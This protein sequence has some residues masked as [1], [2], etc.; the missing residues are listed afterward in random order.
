MI[1]PNIDSI[2][3]RIITI[4][5]V[6]CLVTLSAGFII[7]TVMDIKRIKSNLAD[8]ASIAAKLVGASC[9]SALTFDYPKTA[10]KNLKTLK[11]FPG[12]LNA[13][14]LDSKGAVFA[15]YDPS[16]KLPEKFSNTDKRFFSY[17]DNFLYV[18]EPVV[19]QGKTYGSILLQISPEIKKEIQ[20]RVLIASILVLCLVFI[21]FLLA[22]FA[23]KVISAPILTLAEIS[24]EI[25]SNTNYT[26]LPDHEN[27]GE[28][29]ILYNSFNKMLKTI[30]KREEQRDL[31]QSTLLFKEQVIESSTGAV[32]T[33]DQQG[34]IT[35]I[36]PAFMKLFR[37]IDP[38]NVLGRSFSSFLDNKDT[39]ELMLSSLSRKTQWMHETQARLKD[40][41]LCDVILS[42]DTIFDTLNQL[43][44]I[45]ITVSDVSELRAITR[46][47]EKENRLKTGLQA[48][49]DRLRGFQEISDLTTNLLT[50]LNRFIDFQIGAAYIPDSDGTLVLKGSY[51]IYED[52]TFMTRINPGQGIIGQAALEKRIIHITDIPEN[53]FQ[54]SSG[55]GQAVP[56]S[57][58][59]VPIVFNDELMG[60]LEL[61]SF[62]TF[63]PMDVELL[64]HLGETAAIAIYT[65]MANERRQ[66]L[67][68]KTQAQSEELISQT[69]ELQSQQE[70]LEQTN[71][72]LEEQ[73]QTL[74]EQ[75]IDIKKKNIELEKTSWLVEQKAKDLEITSRYKSEFMANMSH[76][77]RTPLN[78]ILLLS[79]VLAGNKSGNLTEKEI[80]FAKNIYDSGTDLLSLINSILD[81]SKVESGRMELFLEEIALPDIQS[82]MERTFLPFAEKK[83]LSFS[84][85]LDKDLPKA[86]I[87][88]K[89][90]MD[91]ILKNLLSNAFKFT[92]QGSVTLSIKRPSARTK[93]LPME[94]DPEKTISFIVSDTGIGIAKDKTDI[95]FEA[96][97][98][99]DG[100][101]SRKY[102]GTGLGLSIS[103]EI[104]KLLGGTIT[105]SS[106]AGKGSSFTLYLPDTLSLPKDSEDQQQERPDENSRAVDTPSFDGQ[107]PAVSAPDMIETQ[108]F[109]VNDDRHTL[110]HD[111]KSVLIIEDDPG[112]AKILCDHAR[113]QN[114]KTIVAEDGEAGLHL[115]D[116]Y[117]PSAIILDLGLPG[118]DGWSVMERLKKN[119]KTRHI[120]IHII[121]AEKPKQKA[122]EMGAV[123][124][125]AKPADL[126][127]MNEVFSKFSRILSKPVNN[128]LVVEGNDDQ[129]QCIKKIIEN[130]GVNISCAFSAQEAEQLLRQMDFDCLIIDLNLSDF[131]GLDLLSVIEKDKLLCAIPVIVYSENPLSEKEEKILEK[132]AH[133]ITVKS[134]D[135]PERLLDETILFLHRVETSLSEPNRQVLRQLYEKESV[136]KNKTVLVVDDD[137][138]NVFAL[139]NILEEKGLK[140]RAAKTGFEA[141]SSLAKH[142]DT[143]IV[144]MDIMMPEMDGYKA[145]KKIR[146]QKRFEKLPILAL[147]AK[148]MKGDRAKCIEAGA[149][150]YLSKPVDREKLLS[151]IRVWLY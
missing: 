142:P 93:D 63:D 85:Y 137:M 101:T 28:I 74:E 55:S 15:G 47:L 83:A 125:L 145:M 97:K 115:A 31:A 136:L 21:A 143:D 52:K 27:K 61:G 20:S 130:T 103:K 76:E 122:M 140:I 19:Y 39:L 135:T 29:G 149:N 111:E 129:C 14:L 123:G 151:M 77:L 88:D 146:E 133:S 35:Y 92:S 66:E 124:F 24:E 2:K 72:E 86:M 17:E 51:A 87:S 16:N 25:S 10:A 46:E 13:W 114:F 70:E 75:Q 84:V 96:F 90:K 94:M 110:T 60:I 4:I 73:A 41:A 113:E 32:A 42:A 11:S 148:A 26:I 81:L 98:Q 18:L 131:S 147:T 132:Y 95:V 59:A 36:N 30:K 67:L 127:A 82:V 49:S 80:Y 150:D 62:N 9:V 107:K 45:V 106:E 12:I 6:I 99:V 144:L 141:L 134:A 43:E 78:S 119:L 138:R 7:S 91:Q 126:K 23:Q 139:N 53:Y 100:T 44:S 71:Q 40:G 79:D 37:Y 3:N 56:N 38:K 65:S 54:I 89:Q 102:G 118:I 104:A 58:L 112:F 22:N 64:E 108:S 116:F 109:A 34:V 1:L 120:P 33:T 57:L 121:S 5:V 128:V 50:G 48:I 8:Q 117:R 69:E 105:L 68:E